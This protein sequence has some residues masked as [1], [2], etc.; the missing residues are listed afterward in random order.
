[1]CLEQKSMS[2]TP[3]PPSFEP[4]LESSDT[5]KLAIQVLK[6]RIRDISVE[7]RRD[8]KRAVINPCIDRLKYIVFE[9]TR[10]KPLEMDC[11]SMYIIGIQLD[12][13]VATERAKYN[14]LIKAFQPNKEDLE[15]QGVTFE[16]H[17][18]LLPSDV[19]DLQQ[20]MK[21]LLDSGKGKARF[22][23][24]SK[25]PSLKILKANKKEFDQII[26]SDLKTKRKD[27]KEKYPVEPLYSE[28]CDMLGIEDYQNL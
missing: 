23:K 13:D 3:R 8:L 24:W 17:V 5:V 18:G 15:Q 2:Q 6:K 4:P 21:P 12:V 9:C 1:M 19:D 26:A 11:G 27:D 16:V 25:L 7:D 28:L 20:R 10:G 22:T 14:W